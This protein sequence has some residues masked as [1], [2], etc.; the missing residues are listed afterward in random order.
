MTELRG[1][2]KA[3]NE[4]TI[5]EAEAGSKAVEDAMEVL[6]DYYGS[7]LQVKGPDRDGNTVDDLAPETE[8]DS[9]YHGNQDASKGILGILEV[10]KSDFD[11]T[12]E[13]TTD[14][15]SSSQSAFEEEEGNMKGEIDDKKS[16]KEDLESDVKTAESDLIEYKDDKADAEKMH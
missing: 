11:R 4:K 9:E 7:F 2:E 13:S 14:G 10:I 16:E 1:E 5:E 6:K 3:Q 12:V 8:F 15:E